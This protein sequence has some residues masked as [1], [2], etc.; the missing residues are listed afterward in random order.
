MN[1]SDITLIVIERLHKQKKL[2]L[3]LF[4]KSSLSSHC[5]G[6]E[7]VGTGLDNNASASVRLILLSAAVS[8]KV[9]QPRIPGTATHARVQPR[10]RC[11]TVYRTMMI[12]LYFRFGLGITL[13][14]RLRLG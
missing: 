8:L 7:N 6:S 10:V 11:S 5:S 4:R 9:V 1:L 2:K 14:L 12:E 3:Q 13:G